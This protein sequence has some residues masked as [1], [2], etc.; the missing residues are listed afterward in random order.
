M[1]AVAVGA[2]RRFS[3]ASLPAT[4]WRNGGGQTREIACVPGAS[5]DFD[6]RLSVATI[7]QSGAFSP[8][9]GV[10]RII[11]LL[12]GA[13]VRL[14]VGAGQRVHAL[15]TP[16]APFAFSGDEA[17]QAELVGECQD[18]NVMVRRERLRADVAVHRA[19][20][21]LGAAE[22]GAVLV[23]AGVW[24]LATAAGDMRLTGG[25]GAW[26]QA[27]WDAALTPQDADATVLA[28]R[29]LARDGA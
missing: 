16:L 17:V 4:P 29:I 18:F 25:E 20:L 24:T 14:R 13:G 3:L 8:F 5:G 2:P 15:T 28:V 26:W 1:D 22:G 6:W 10:D 9:P 11:T 7:A 12:S 27:G 23:T 19:A 21:T